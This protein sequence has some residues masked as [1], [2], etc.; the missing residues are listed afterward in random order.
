MTNKQTDWLTDSII[1]LKDL[2][3]R[4]HENSCSKTRRFSINTKS[5]TYSQTFTLR[6]I[7]ILHSHLRFYSIC[8]LHVPPILSLTRYMLVSCP[9]TDLNGLS[10][11]LFVR[12]R[13]FHFI[14]KLFYVFHA[15]YFPCLWNAVNFTSSL[16]KLQKRNERVSGRL[17][18]S[19][20]MTICSQTLSPNSWMD[21]D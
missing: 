15:P 1:F 3:P 13:G 10:S 12:R 17:Y 2:F 4:G 9:E 21:F 6:F 18:L 19:V 14:A 16:H 5:F 8:M 7:L 11:S 20:G